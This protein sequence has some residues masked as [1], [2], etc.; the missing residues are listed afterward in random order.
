MTAFQAFLK[1]WQVL[2]S[3]SSKKTEEKQAEPKS[4]PKEPESSEKTKDDHPAKSQIKDEKKPSSS[5]WN[6][7]MFSNNPAAGGQGGSGQQGQG[8]P[9]GGEPEGPDS[10]LLLY[11]ALGFLAF[12]GTIAFVEMG[13]KEISWKD[14]VNK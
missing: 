10:K 11:G 4:Q 9:I 6:L 8:R 13:Y 5:D 12:V 3:Q 14:F 1:Q 2:L 7:G